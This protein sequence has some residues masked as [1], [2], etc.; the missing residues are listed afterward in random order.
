MLTGIMVS[1]MRRL[2]VCNLH[3]PEMWQSWA[4]DTLGSR[5][6]RIFINGPCANIMLLGEGNEAFCTWHLFA[7][8]LLYLSILHALHDLLLLAQKPENQCQSLLSMLHMLIVPNGS[9]GTSETGV[10]RILMLLYI[11]SCRGR[12]LGYQGR[13]GRLG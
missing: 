10:R 9:K 2:R 13:I 6:L 3:I 8:F 5:R 12:R 1:H 7:R 11:Q 4:M